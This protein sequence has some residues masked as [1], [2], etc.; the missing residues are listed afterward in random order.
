VNGDAAHFRAASRR[1]VRRLTAAG[2]F[3]A[4]RRTALPAFGGA[5]ALAAALRWCGVAHAGTAGGALLAA[6][7]GG[8]LLWAWRTRPDAA[9]A[10][11]VW[12]RRA[13][14]HEMFVS[15]YCFEAAEEAGP[16]ER[17]HLARARPRLARE[18]DTMHRHLPAPV[19]HRGWLLA[20]AFATL[21]A[22]GLFDLPL[23]RDETPLDPDA[24]ARAGKAGDRIV[25]Q[26]RV[27]DPLKGLTDDE[28][29]KAAALKL[30]LRK[31]ADRLKAEDKK[32]P[33]DVLEDLEKRARDA[34]KL[35]DALAAGGLSEV[36]SDLIA[37][38]ERHADTAELAAGLR[39]RDL[40]KTAA[41]ADKL[42]ARLRRKEMSLEEQKRIEN[43]LKS[44]L[45][46]GKPKDRKSALG[47]HLSRAQRQLQQKKRRLA[48]NTFR[49]LANHYNRALQRL[50]SRRQLQQLARNLR[51]AGRQIFGQNPVGMRRLSPQL[52]G[53]QP[54]GPVRRLPVGLLRGRRGAG[55]RR[56][57]LVG[58]MPGRGR[59]GARPGAMIPVPGSGRGGRLGGVMPGGAGGGQVPVPG[60]GGMAGASTPGGGGGVGGL[61]AGHGT[62]PLGAKPTAPLGA[63]RTGVVAPNVGEEGETE[64]RRLEGRMHKE[65]TARRARDVVMKQIRAAEEALDEEPLPLTRRDQVLRYFTALRRQVEHER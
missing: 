65:E 9:R 4:V 30:D 20:A 16:G 18:L 24:Q 40:G 7:V 6:W 26:A 5:V 45:K 58:W 2:W 23:S 37:E 14:R 61:Q 41:E 1:A 32:T 50:Q 10:L 54:L 62:A 29:E 3:D 27:I 25:E 34:E 12:D 39:A 11:A 33:R 55:G 35:A 63:S 43:A 28:R 8:T 15:A 42:A 21:A 38:L 48:S 57:R 36:S 60:G 22:L 19:P 46:A 64:V 13:E 53:L 51:Q 31:T 44:A 59:P 49:N 47:K 52:A 56:G 17:L